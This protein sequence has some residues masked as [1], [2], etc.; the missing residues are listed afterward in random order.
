[1]TAGRRR[2]L[3]FCR[4]GDAS[5]HRAWLGDPATRSYDVW[6]DSYA[7]DDARW[8]GDP[9]RVTVAR[10]TVKIQRIAVS[11]LTPA[12]FEEIAGK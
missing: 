1:V 3:V 8:A 2:N 5:L 7:S 6:L 4:V 12:Q 9:A 10:D 11:P